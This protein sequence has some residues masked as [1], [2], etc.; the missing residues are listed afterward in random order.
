MVPVS[1]GF[2]NASYPEEAGAGFAVD[3][4]GVN[5][6][7]SASPI[8]LSANYTMEAWI[9]PELT[10]TI[11][12]VVGNHS[13]GVGSPGVGIFVNQ[14]GNPDSSLNVEGGGWNIIVP[15]VI[16]PNEWQHVAVTA[17]GTNARLFLNGEVIGS[18]TI[19]NNPTGANL[20]IGAFPD[21]AFYFQ[22]NIDEVR[23]WDAEL[24]TATIRQYMTQKVDA[25]HPDF[26]N[27]QSYYRMDEGSG[28]SVFDLMASNDASY[29]D[30][31]AAFL[32]S[33]SGANLGDTAFFT[34]PAVNILEATYN[35][36]SV[37]TDAIQQTTGPMSVYAINDTISGNYPSYFTYIDSANVIG[38]RS[39]RDS[40]FTLALSYGGNTNLNVSNEDQIRVLR[41]K[42]GEESR[43]L[44]ASGVFDVDESGN[45]VFLENTKEGE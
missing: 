14:F 15:G 36:F 16:Q 1:S 40:T 12:G 38:A 43:W 26:A 31:D 39:F 2:T 7:I 45:W 13:S 10:G 8:T 4:D 35:G 11:M 33:R 24:S 41:R 19:N 30:P 23:I 34:F 6:R 29:I 17:N 22:G 44:P 28:N 25:N 42:N 5:D 21:P 3:L 20:T 27:L 18:G 32:W 9:K 37:R